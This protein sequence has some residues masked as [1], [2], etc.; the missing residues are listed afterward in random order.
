M[1]KAT[2]HVF[3]TLKRERDA[4]ARR[5]RPTFPLFNSAKPG[6]SQRPDEELLKGF[7]ER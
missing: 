1:L 5:R 6:L 7:G 2:V 4:L 3:A